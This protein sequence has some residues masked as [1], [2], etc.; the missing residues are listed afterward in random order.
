MEKGNPDKV[1]DKNIMALISSCDYFGLEPVMTDFFRSIPET[2]RTKNIDRLIVLHDNSVMELSG[3][4]L[5]KRAHKEMHNL[6]QQSGSFYH[7][8]IADIKNAIARG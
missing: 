5:S 1:T 2:P 3:E 6:Y 7:K 8:S 4:T